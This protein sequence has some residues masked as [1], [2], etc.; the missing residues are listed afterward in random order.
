MSRLGLPSPTHSD[1]SFC[2][3]IFCPRNRKFLPVFSFANS[4]VKIKWLALQKQYTA[5][6][7]RR[8]GGSALSWQCVPLS[9]LAWPVNRGVQC[10]MLEI[11][12]LCSI[13]A[14][15]C[16]SR[17]TGNARRN[18]GIRCQNRLPPLQPVGVVMYTHT[19]MHTLATI[20]ISQQNRHSKQ[21]IIQR[22]LYR[23]CMLQ[24]YII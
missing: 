23:T 14:L 20:T 12:A 24:H 8:G 18:N 11:T 7:T 4:V 17:L 22:Q 5:M 6:P 1:D 3:R 2:F 19:T 10:I 9:R 15:Y 13:T 21:V 16:T